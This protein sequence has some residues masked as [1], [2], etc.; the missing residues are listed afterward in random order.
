MVNSKDIQLQ[1]EKIENAVKLAVSDMRVTYP[2]LSASDGEKLAT[3]FINRHSI[4]L[5]NENIT[6]IDKITQGI[7]DNI[8]SAVVSFAITTNYVQATKV[9]FGKSVS[10]N[11]STSDVS[12]SYK[13]QQEQQELKEILNYRKELQKAGV[14]ASSEKWCKLMLAKFPNSEKAVP[15]V[16]KEKFNLK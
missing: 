16:L 2:L 8:P 4:T 1:K 7:S 14:A 5:T 13:E 9:G 11:L 10:S 6:V 15:T 3:D 12:S